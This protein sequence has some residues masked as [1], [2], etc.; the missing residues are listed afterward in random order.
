MLVIEGG[1]AVALSDSSWLQM[2]DAIAGG[3]LASATDYGPEV[4]QVIGEVT[5]LASSTASGVPVASFGDPFAE[6][7]VL[8]D[9]LAYALA[10]SDWLS[11]LALRLTGD[12][13]PPTAYGSCLGPVGPVIEEIGPRDAADLASVI[14]RQSFQSIATRRAA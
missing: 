3:Q 2:L 14:R 1:H 6:L 9:G 5:T 10:P 12:L 11:Y 7:V 13:S 8:H 4:G